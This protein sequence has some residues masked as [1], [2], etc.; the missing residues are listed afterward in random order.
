MR[1]SHNNVIKKLDSARLM[2]FTSQKS[3]YMM[4][5]KV[6]LCMVL[7]GCQYLDTAMIFAYR[8]VSRS[9]PLM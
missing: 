6:V 5:G 7:S 2:Y 1:V 9:F 4:E 3:L 8:T